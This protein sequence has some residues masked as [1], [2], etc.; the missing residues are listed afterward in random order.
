MC[1]VCDE[2]NIINANVDRGVELY[3]P[4]DF[5]FHTPISKFN[6]G[7]LRVHINANHPDFF[8]VVASKHMELLTAQIT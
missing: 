8:S 6:V 1:D 4:Y 3:Q 7:T 2:K 5:C